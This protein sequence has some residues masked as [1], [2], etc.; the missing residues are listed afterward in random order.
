LLLP[1]GAYF[2]GFRFADRLVTGDRLY[3]VDATSAPLDLGDCLGMPTGPCAT[4]P[5]T[6]VVLPNQDV[7]RMEQVLESLECTQR[8]AIRA[9]VR[10][11]YAADQL[12]G[13]FTDIRAYASPSGSSPQV[14]ENVPSPPPV[15]VD[16]GSVVR[17]EPDVSE[18]EGDARAVGVKTIRRLA[19]VRRQACPYPGV[20]WMVDEVV[21]YVAPYWLGRSA[22]LTP[23][24]GFPSLRCLSANYSDRS[25]FDA[26]RSSITGVKRP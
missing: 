3:R 12:A 13:P 20:G 8:P 16:L 25:I 24:S 10:I 26:R 4:W 1:P 2:F 5:G 14:S 19:Q 15:V 7:A 23:D 22:G 17:C 18:D 9:T 11:H 21:G 6:L